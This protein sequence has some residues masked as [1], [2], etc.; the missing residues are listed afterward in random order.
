MTTVYA[1]DS[2]C[3][4]ADLSIVLQCSLSACLS[5]FVEFQSLETSL[6]LHE[7]TAGSHLCLDV[8][9]TRL[10][11]LQRTPGAPSQRSGVI[12]QATPSLRVMGPVRHV[13]ILSRRWVTC[14]PLALAAHAAVAKAE[15]AG[16]SIDV[17]QCLRPRTSHALCQALIE[18]SVR[19]QGRASG[20]VFML[21]AVQ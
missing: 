4:H 19:A 20:A 6:P 13:R 11:V 12:D 16:S 18:V 15:T 21:F 10:L 2:G 9:S 7:V 5:R 1:G 8:K 17:C 3:D 14:I